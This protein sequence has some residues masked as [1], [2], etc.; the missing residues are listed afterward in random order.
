[1][2]KIL[3]IPNYYYPHIGG[4]EQTTRD[5][6]DSL[7]GLYEQKVICFNHEKKTAS[8]FVDETEIIRVKC[9]TKIASQSIALAYGKVLKRTIKEFNPDIVIFHYPNPFVAHSL[10]KHLKNKKF[11]F[12]LYWHLDITKQKL[13]GKFF[14]GQTRRL[15]NKADLVIT[16]SPNYLAHSEFLPLYKE[17][18]KVIPSCV[19]NYV[20]KY[21]DKHLA[22]S[23]EYKKK[24]EGKI[25]LFTFGRHVEYK[26]LEYLIEASKY[27]N[28]DYKILIGGKGPLTESLKEMA[29]DDNKIEFLGRL[30]DDDVKA[31]LLL[32][33]I[34]CFPSITKNEAFGLAL[35]EAMAYGNPAITFTIEGSGV[36][37][38]NL[39]NV[40]GLEVPNRDSKAFAEAVISMKD[41]INIF[42]P[43]AKERVEELFIFDV[44]KKNIISTI[45]ELI[46]EKNNN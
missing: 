45:E 23:D 35:A 40:T 13:L 12:I 10:V 3:H 27:L 22:L 15:L 20:V 29:K 33:D 7:R 25:I 21:N 1:M 14:K 9:Q 4:I 38:V 41:K 17:K 16:T 6:V 46:N 37:Y 18:C 43:K 24:Y 44:F 19:S 30:S 26:G 8:D 32:C 36:N 34:F 31:Y 5:I 11:K 42:G 28:D 39:A 2:Q